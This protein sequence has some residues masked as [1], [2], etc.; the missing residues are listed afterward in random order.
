MQR[1]AWPAVTQSPPGPPQSTKQQHEVSSMSLFFPELEEKKKQNC[2][3]GWF[4]LLTSS[5]LC[6]KCCLFE[7]YSFLL[8]YSDTHPP[9]CISGGNLL[10]D[11]NKSLLQ[12]LLSFSCIQTSNLS[13]F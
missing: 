8:V 10:E 12:N 7:N 11:G 2:W 3:A 13:H 1:A 9:I 4:S 6:C 5:A